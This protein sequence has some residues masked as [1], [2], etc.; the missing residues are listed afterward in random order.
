MANL[1]FYI[2]SFNRV[3]TFLDGAGTGNWVCPAGVTSITVECWGAG[4]AG[5]SVTSYTSG[6]KIGAGGGGGA[7]SKSTISVT[8][9][10][11]YPFSIGAAGTPA[12]NGGDTTFKTTTVVAKGGGSV[13]Q[14]NNFGGAASSGTGD[15]R[16]SGGN[17][18]AGGINGSIVISGP[19]GAAAGPGGNG[20]NAVAVVNF[21]SNGRP[22]AEFTLDR[23]VDVGSAWG[24]GNTYFGYK[25]GGGMYSVTMADD[26]T[27]NSKA[28]GNATN[29]WSDPSWIRCYPGGAGSGAL[30]Y[31]NVGTIAGGQGAPGLIIISYKL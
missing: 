12:A 9:G 17:G 21:T 19:G 10:T 11:S 7:Y 20:D 3:T 4:G 15:V 24:Y 22:G 14:G 23:Y 1:R 28:G 29:W 27:K 6:Y 13:N 25:Y 31:G 26:T 8:P 30:A 16:Y 18:A 5:E 2:D